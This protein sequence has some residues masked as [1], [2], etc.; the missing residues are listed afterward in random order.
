MHISLQLISSS[1]DRFILDYKQNYPDFTLVKGICKTNTW[2]YYN[3]RD[4]KVAICDPE[5]APKIADLHGVWTYSLT[6]SF[7]LLSLPAEAI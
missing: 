4:Y 2:C 3:C 6:L 5:T 7:N 1:D